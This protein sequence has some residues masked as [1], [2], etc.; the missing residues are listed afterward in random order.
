MKN[1]EFELNGLTCAICGR[2]AAD[3]Q[4]TDSDDCKNDTCQKCFAFLASVS[5]LMIES[6]MFHFQ[7]VQRLEYKNMMSYLAKHYNEYED[8]SYL[9]TLLDEK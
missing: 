2:L 8:Q 5:P 9:H 4:K 1:T 3:W 7:A 6:K